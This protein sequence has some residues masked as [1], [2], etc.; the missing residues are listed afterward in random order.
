MVKVC[1]LGNFLNNF[2]TRVQTFSNSYVGYCLAREPLILVYGCSLY[3]EY[4]IDM[5]STVAKEIQCLK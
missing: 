4:P 1:E 2:F 3:I 5:K